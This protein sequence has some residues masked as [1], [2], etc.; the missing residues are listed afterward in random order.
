[1]LDNFS[2][3]IKCIVSGQDFHI[4]LNF[5][6]YEKTQIDTVHFSIS[7]SDYRENILLHLSNSVANGSEFKLSQDFET[8]S[9]ICKVFNFPLQPGNY[10]IH[11]F[12]SDLNHVYDEIS[13]AGE[14]SVEAGSFFYSGK[15]PPKG[16][17]LVQNNWTLK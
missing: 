14:I 11:L 2:N 17:F 10:I 7:I 15:L 3:P 12:C 4:K 8:G 13:F 5:N 6:K 9:V 16:T 1:L